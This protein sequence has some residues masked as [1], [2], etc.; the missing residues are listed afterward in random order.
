MKRLHC[1]GSISETY[2]LLLYLLTHTFFF[3]YLKFKLCLFKRLNLQK[4]RFELNFFFLSW[5]VLLLKK[6][7]S[8]VERVK[9]HGSS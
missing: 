6:A 7:M 4:Y 1:F 9:P 2:L 5:I 8:R 3:C